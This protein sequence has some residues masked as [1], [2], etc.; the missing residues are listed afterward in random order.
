MRLSKKAKLNNARVCIRD[1]AHAAGRRGDP[2]TAIN[3]INP[4]NVLIQLFNGWLIE[5]RLTTK[6][7]NIPYCKTV[8]SKFI[9]S[10]SSI[11]SLIYH[12]P[13]NTRIFRKYVTWLLENSSDPC[14]VAGSGC[15]WRWS[16][17][18]Q[19]KEESRKWKTRNLCFAK[20]RHSSVLKPASRFILHLTAVVNAAMETLVANACWCMLTFDGSQQVQVADPNY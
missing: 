5:L 14:P 9:W 16:L 20:H 10:S 11:I 13:A 8:W 15:H 18:G 4:V 17:L 6:W 19:V 3:P 1:G 12:S 7:N 2:V